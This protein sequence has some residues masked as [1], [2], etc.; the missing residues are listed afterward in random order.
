MLGVVVFVGDA[1]DAKRAYTSNRTRRKW[2]REEEKK[3][4]TCSIYI[5]FKKSLDLMNYITDLKWKK[6]GCTNCF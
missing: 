2:W 4:A 6:S 1:N 5:V 3:T